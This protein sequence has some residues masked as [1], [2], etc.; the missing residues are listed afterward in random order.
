ME[1]VEAVDE[2]V[3]EVEAEETVHVAPLVVV[4]EEAEVEDTVKDAGNSSRRN[5]LRTKT[6]KANYRHSKSSLKRELRRTT[7]PMSASSAQTP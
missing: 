6:R 4:A 2:E 5:N 7:M 3:V 1:A